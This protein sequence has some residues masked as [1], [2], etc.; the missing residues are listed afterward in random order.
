MSPGR[1][2]DWIMKLEESVEAIIDSQKLDEEQG[3]SLE[4]L[5]YLYGDRH[6]F[7]QRKAGFL[8]LTGSTTREDMLCA[9]LAAFRSCL[10]DAGREVAAAVGRPLYS[11]VTSGGFDI[12]SMSHHRRSAFDHSNLIPLEVAVIRGAAV[13]AA[14]ALEKS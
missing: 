5:P 11:I 8:G 12:S 7:E 2:W 4:F 13:L 14:R 9:V 6:S 3:D 10:R 1:F